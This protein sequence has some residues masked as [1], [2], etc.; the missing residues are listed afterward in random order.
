MT[1]DGSGHGLPPSLATHIAHPSGR[2]T[3]TEESLARRDPV[4]SILTPSFS[5]ARWLEDNLRSVEGQTYAGIEHLVMDGAST[6]GSVEIL[7]R[8][9]RPGLTWESSPDNGQSDAINKA[10]ARSTG[11]IIGWLNSDDAYFASDVVANAVEVF[12]AHPEVG[13]VYGHAALVSGDGTLLHALWTPRFARSML[14]AY[15]LIVQPTIF[16]RRSVLGRPQFVDPA[17]DYCMDWELLLHLAHRTRFVRMDRIVSIDRHHLLRKSLT[18]LDLAARDNVLMAER[19]RISRLAAN[20]V[21]LKATTI[22]ARLAGLSMVREAARGSDLLDLTVPPAR[23]IAV[24]QVAQ[25]RRW[26]PSGDGQ[27]AS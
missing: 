9:V 6:D 7:Q 26:M 12:A 27:G 10:F 1:P 4:V 24:R 22:A 20:R 2:M 17:F 11:E 3:L 19:Y 15:D 5:Q 23:K 21:L 16:V 18:R 8:R 25:L 13:V 14:R